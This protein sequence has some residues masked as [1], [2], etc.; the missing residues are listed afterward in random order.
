[1]PPAL[2]VTTHVDPENRGQFLV[3]CTCSKNPIGTMALLLPVR[4]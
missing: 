2:H 4:V 1:M 3:A